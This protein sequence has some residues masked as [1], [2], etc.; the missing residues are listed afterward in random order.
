MFYLNQA[1]DDYNVL[2][3]NLKKLKYSSWIPIMFLSDFKVLLDRN[4]Y[5]NPNRVN[6][7]KS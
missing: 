5:L 6:W 4:Q 7:N 2:T 1:K 3:S